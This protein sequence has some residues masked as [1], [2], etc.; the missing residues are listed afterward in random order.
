MRACAPP[1]R[2]SP[3]ARRCLMAPACE[4]GQLGTPEGWWLACSWWPLP[5]G[6]TE[7]DECRSCPILALPRGQQPVRGVPAGQ[8]P[9]LGKAAC[10][11]GGLLTLPISPHTDRF[12]V[13]ELRISRAQVPPS[14]LRSCGSEEL[15]RA[16]SQAC[17]AQSLGDAGPDPRSQSIPAGEQGLQS[18]GHR[19]K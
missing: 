4:K 18:P 3:V 12:P 11:A 5:S 9:S 15:G 19:R 7:P 16:S 13:G 17:L 2:P 6:A 1:R 10:R 8:C 14:C